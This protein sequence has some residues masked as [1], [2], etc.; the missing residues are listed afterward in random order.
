MI[1]IKRADETCSELLAELGSTTY[2][3]SHGHFIE[4]KNDL[5]QYNA[6]AFS[7]SKT[8]RDLNDANNLF[9]IIYTDNMAV[10]YAKLLIDA[11]HESVD[12]KNCC[13]L[14]RI[15]ILDRFIYLKIGQQLLDF[16]EEEARKLRLDTMWLSVYVKN[17]RAIRFYEKNGFG[18]VGKLRFLVN[19]KEYENLIFSKKL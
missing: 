14:E 18:T 13:R 3:E 6:S 16:I 11:P 15:Y 17:E 19:E 10:G 2:S 7:V 8:K 5:L 1:E 12:S 4:N 9:Y